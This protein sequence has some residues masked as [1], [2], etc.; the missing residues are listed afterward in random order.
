MHHYLDFEVLDGKPQQVYP[1]R[2]GETHRGQYAAEDWAHHNCFHDDE[3]LVDAGD[4]QA[5]CSLCG[6][7]FSLKISAGR[8]NAD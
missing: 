6:N 3:L 1:C 4:D 7:V 5:M 8:I 2:C